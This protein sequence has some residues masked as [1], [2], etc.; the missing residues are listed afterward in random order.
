MSQNEK[1]DGCC[2]KFA[3]TSGLCC[4][5]NPN[6]YKH[7][8]LAEVVQNDR[9]RCTDLPCCL[10]LL[11]GI[12]SEIYLIIYS[13]NNGAEPKLLMY[14]YDSRIL[15]D[16]ASKPMICDEDN[17]NGHYAIWPDLFH[18]GYFYLFVHQ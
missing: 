18:T 5:M 3:T 12:I 13:T 9:R 10:I 8:P 17:S 4:F 7:K 11:F 15:D 14:G 6:D 2:T 1:E 16:T